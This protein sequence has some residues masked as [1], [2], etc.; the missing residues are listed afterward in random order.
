MSA[1][2]PNAFARLIRNRW[3]CAA[4]AS[5]L[6]P[7]ALCA[8]WEPI[9]ACPVPEGEPFVDLDNIE[10]PWV[11]LAAFPIRP[12]TVTPDGDVWAVNTQDSTLVHY[13]GATADEN[14]PA[15]MPWFPVSV[16]YWHRDPGDAEDYEMLVVCR[17]TWTLARV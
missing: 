10:G 15:R 17:G 2:S 4:L 14:G 6:A 7:A 1:S 5:A 9:E 3:L 8:Q 11:G 16:A 12:M 13:V